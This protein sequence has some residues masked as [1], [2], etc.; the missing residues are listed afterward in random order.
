MNQIIELSSDNYDATDLIRVINEVSENGQH[1][2]QI[3]LM[4]AG[5]ENGKDHDEIWLLR[6]SPKN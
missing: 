5:P 4:I 2:I 6:D 1:K 3:F